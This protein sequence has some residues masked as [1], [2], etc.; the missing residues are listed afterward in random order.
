MN[1]K[2]GLLTK[3]EVKMAGY[4]YFLHVY[5]PR[6][7]R[8]MNSKIKNRPISSYLDRKKLHHMYTYMKIRASFLNKPNQKWHNDVL[9]SRIEPLKWFTKP[10]RQ[11]RC[12]IMSKSYG[13]CNL[14]VCDITRKEKR[15]STFRQSCEAKDNLSSWVPSNCIVITDLKT[16]YQSCMG[17]RNKERNLLLLNRNIFVLSKCVIS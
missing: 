5:G 6:Q 17:G 2:Y 3:H 15:T 1:L 13:I 11:S 9:T 14:C 16:D 10:M 8:S 4:R 7:M 12:W